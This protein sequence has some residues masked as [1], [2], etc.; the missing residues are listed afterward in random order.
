MKRLNPEGHSLAFFFAP[1]TQ[2]IPLSALNIPLSPWPSVWFT[3]LRKHI[4]NFPLDFPGGP[5]IK[6]PGF[7][8]RGFPGQ[9]TKIPNAVWHS[10]QKRKFPINH[11]T[12][13]SLLWNYTF[14]LYN[15]MFGNS[16]YF[17]V[18]DISLHQANAW[19]F[20]ECI[21]QNG[22]SEK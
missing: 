13:L 14:L 7:H 21:S 9:G 11:Q 22:N 5:V 16:K 4:R 15:S 20:L 18:E 2:R 12:F 1:L 17:S 6:T 10:P 3:F 19:G 8:C